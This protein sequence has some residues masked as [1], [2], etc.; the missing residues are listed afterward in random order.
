MILTKRNEQR[1]FFRFAIVGAIGAVVDF[2]LFNLL[3]AVLHVDTVV[4]S[5]ISFVAAVLNNFLWNRY[6]TYPDSRS[7]S[8]STQIIQFAAI[9]V[10]GLLIRTPL[11]AFLESATVPVFEKMLP[12]NFFFSAT[13]LGHN[14]SLATAILVVMMWNFFANR[15]WTYNDVKSD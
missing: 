6:W 11:F 13:F 5:V 3:S 4:S 12:S 7:K 1:R 9:N 8:V 15:L 10:I 2:G 14:L